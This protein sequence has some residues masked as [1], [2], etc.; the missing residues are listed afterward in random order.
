MP[1]LVQVKLTTRFPGLSITARNYLDVYIYD[2]WKGNIL[3]DFQVGE[4]FIPEVCQ[5]KQGQT[6]CPS[7]LTEAD[8]VSLMDKNGIGTFPPT[9]FLAELLLIRLLFFLPFL[10]TDATIAEH[11]N[12]I[13]EREYVM[14]QREGNTEYL[15]PSTL[16]IGLVEGYNAV[17]FETSLS[18]PH[19]RRLVRPFPPQF[20]D[21]VLPRGLVLTS[22]TYHRLNIEWLKSAMVSKRSEKF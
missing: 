17:G 10:G 7:L 8:L 2:K 22:K 21:L 19:L 9:S 13:I 6:S 5:I 18:K 14:K 1:K 12:K 3:P 20:H 15:V 16:G 11:I 4:S